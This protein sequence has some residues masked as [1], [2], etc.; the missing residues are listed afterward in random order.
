MD[1][2]DKLIIVYQIC[3]DFFGHKLYY[4]KT[5]STLDNEL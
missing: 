5:I 2:C 1:I 4:N 3:E